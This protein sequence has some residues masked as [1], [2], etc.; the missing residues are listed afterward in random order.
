MTPRTREQNAYARFAG[1]MYFF[2]VFDVTGVVIAARVSGTGNFLDTAHNVAASDALYRIGLV[3]GPLFCIAS[4]RSS[5]RSRPSPPA[6]RHEAL[7]VSR[8]EAR[9]SETRSPSASP[10]SG[11]GEPRA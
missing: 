2:T 6:T 5:C 9:T 1:V 11:P 8:C 3:S 4:S 7:D 10:S